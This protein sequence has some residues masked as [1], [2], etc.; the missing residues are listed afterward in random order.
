MSTRSLDRCFPYV[1]VCTSYRDSKDAIP[2]RGGVF[3]KID[4][5]I[6]IGTYEKGA[7]P[8]LHSLVLPQELSS[9]LN[10]PAQFRS[11]LI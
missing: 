2:N 7:R 1:K 9:T 8:V 6:T 11:I 5:S 10:E 4:K 3:W